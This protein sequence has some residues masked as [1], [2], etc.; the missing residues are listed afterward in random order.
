MM[1]LSA[2]LCDGLKQ[3]MPLAEKHGG[4]NTNGVALNS[5][6]NHEDYML[7]PTLN[8]CGIV[9]KIGVQ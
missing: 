6:V 2:K 8:G 5:K 9:Q 3:I 4:S 1:L 7:R